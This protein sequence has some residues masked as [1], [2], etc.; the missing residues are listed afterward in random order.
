MKEAIE[1]S[2]VD[3]EKFKKTINA[4]T[5]FEP[6]K[7]WVEKQKDE[8]FQ[9]LFKDLWP[10]V[11]S[12]INDSEAKSK[13]A[14]ANQLLAELERKRIECEN[15]VK[16][17]LSHVHQ[18]S[19]HYS[20]CNCNSACNCLKVCQVPTP[21]PA[22]PAEPPKKETKEETKKPYPNLVSSYDF[23]W[24][25][26]K[27][28]DTLVKSSY[29]PA[30]LEVEKRLLKNI[31]DS[32]EKLKEA[33]KLNKTTELVD[34]M[35]VKFKLLQDEM[36][37]KSEALRLKSELE[38]L[39]KEVRRS[40][41]RSRSKSLSRR[42]K[43]RSVSATSSSSSDKSISRERHV[44]KSATYSILKPA[45]PVGSCSHSKVR[46]SHDS[47]LTA[48]TKAI[49]VKPKVKCWNCNCDCEKKTKTKKIDMNIY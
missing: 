40:T 2:D 30:E 45:K 21:P 22:K 25:L 10:N 17:D 11:Y 13:P 39:R 16:F 18:Y 23:P 26:Y 9:S 8:K 37:K 20:H 38:E 1:V 43:S 24:P 7:E 32:Q 34:D 15:R 27:F 44:C 46:H 49:Y 6:T 5:T 4:K 29:N 3:Y 41:E 19:H 48:A 35:I 31:Q 12:R 28:T 42:H 36:K 14:S 47:Y 33:Q